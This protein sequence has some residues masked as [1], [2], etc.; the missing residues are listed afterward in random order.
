MRRWGFVSY[1]MASMVVVA[2]A[3][4][5]AQSTAGGSRWEIEVHGGGGFDNRPADG[6]G[7]L[8]P[9]GQPFVTAVGATSRRASTWSFG[10]GAVLLNQINTS[11]AATAFP[12]SGRITP[13]DSILQSAAA[14]RGHGASWGFRVGM[15]ITP[16]FGAEFTL[17]ATQGQVDF[18]DEARAGIEATRASFITALNDRTGLLYSGGGV[19]F[20]NAVVTSTAA[21]DEPSGR[22][23]FT[24]GALTI[25]LARQG[26][27]VPYAVVGAGVVSSVGDLPSTTL[28][29]NYRFSSLGA[30][31]GYF[32]VDET[33]TVRIGLVSVKQHPLV[34]VF[35]GGVKY[36]RSSRWGLRGDV[37]AYVSKNTM[38]V[39]VSATPRV[40]TTSTPPG[41]IAST[42][43]PG[44]QF[45]NLPSV[46]LSTLTG[47]PIDG[48]TTFSSSGTSLHLNVTA[49]YYVK[50]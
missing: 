43:T 44:I 37:R 19:V 27:L 24:T 25:N 47:P 46:A 13:L 45:T 39:Q 40:V 32:P 6:S 14:Q 41:V 5:L 22:Q 23:L 4:A 29:G 15:A 36:Q 10:D 21:I 48:F 38:D 17:D 34:T 16:R 30:L 20:T 1:L 33:D 7:A 12:P 8:P 35:G 9:A 3:G 50:F 42:L 28:T 26:R 11:F 49:G 18:T 31:T 2:P